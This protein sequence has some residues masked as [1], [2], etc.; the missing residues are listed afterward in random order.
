M[1]SI[2]Q[3]TRH[4][5]SWL[6]SEDFHHLFEQ[7]TT[8]SQMSEEAFKNW[9][10]KLL[11]QQNTYMYGVLINHNQL[12]GIGVLL[13]EEKYYRQSSANKPGKS[14]HIEDIIIDKEHRGRKLGKRL[15]QFMKQQAQEKGCYKIQLHCG[16]DLETF[17]KKQ[18]FM[19]NK[20]SMETYF[21]EQ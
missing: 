3:M 9:Y 8:S 21:T 11:S 13:I 6:K 5:W 7:L 1:Y 17:Y 12:V 4:E 15:I 18:G 19:S 20:V 2:R 16:K 10:V 14:G